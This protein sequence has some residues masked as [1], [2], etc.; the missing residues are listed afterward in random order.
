[1]APKY[2]ITVIDRKKKFDN[3]TNVNPKKSNAQGIFL[4]YF[5][6]SGYLKK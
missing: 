4:L 5:L 2:V 1:M 6:I 3:P